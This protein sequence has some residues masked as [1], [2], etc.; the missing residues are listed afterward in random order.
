M[1]LYCLKLILLTWQWPFIIRT[2]IIGEHRAI[3]SSSVQLNILQEIEFHLRPGQYCLHDY[4]YFPLFQHLKSYRVMNDCNH[5]KEELALLQLVTEEVPHRKELIEQSFDH[6]SRHREMSGSIREG[7]GYMVREQK[8]KRKGEVS[9]RVG[10]Q[11][12]ASESYRGNELCGSTCECCSVAK[13]CL[14][15]GPHS[16]FIR[17]SDLAISSEGEARVIR[18]TADPFKKPSWYASCSQTARGL[19]LTEEPRW[20]VKFEGGSCFP[21]GAILNDALERTNY[22]GLES[23]A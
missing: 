15:K 20:K 9:W 13:D 5:L 16:A 14:L 4:G 7:R 19:R 23:V 21:S 8:N 3:E 18:A 10:I 11:E 1:K 22:Q 12:E 6:R 17:S 2:A